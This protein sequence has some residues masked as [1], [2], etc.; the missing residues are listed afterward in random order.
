MTNQLVLIGTLENVSDVHE[1]LQDTPA[2]M[3]EI[4]EIRFQLETEDGL[5]LDATAA[6]NNGTAFYALFHDPLFAEGTKTHATGY[7]IP[8]H[9]IGAPLFIVQILKRGTTHQTLAITSD[10]Q[11]AEELA[12]AAQSNLY[13]DKAA[14]FKLLDTCEPGSPQH[15]A[16]ATQLRRQHQDRSP[17][18]EIAEKEAV[19]N[20]CK[21]AIFINTRYVYRFSNDY[22]DT[23]RT[24]RPFDLVDPIPPEEKAPPL[25][26][27]EVMKRLEERFPP[28]D[29]SGRNRKP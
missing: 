18:T 10:V 12:S 4:R 21:A 24:N 23:C 13:M 19:C 26:L 9:G 28:K 29:R 20:T 3:K 8:Q 27:E 22:C 25:P 6:T 15:Y 17:E 14:L 1:F 7:L 11:T 2:G 16:I 5:R